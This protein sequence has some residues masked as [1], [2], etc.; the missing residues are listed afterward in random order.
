MHELA[1]PTTV[2]HEG[3]TR[4]PLELYGRSFSPFFLATIV[5]ISHPSTSSGADFRRNDNVC[6]ETRRDL[7]PDTTPLEL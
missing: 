7:S 1:A 4:T 3:G 5:F 2:T 6:A